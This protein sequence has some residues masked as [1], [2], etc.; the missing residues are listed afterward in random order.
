MKHV[1]AVPVSAVHP[2]I[3]EGPGIGKVSS[4]PPSEAA[5]AREKAPSSQEH[6]QPQKQSAARRPR[7]PTEQQKP[8]NTSFSDS[9]SFPEF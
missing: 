9:C 8:G 7:I 5:G 3:S 2:P 1:L 4:E 6:T